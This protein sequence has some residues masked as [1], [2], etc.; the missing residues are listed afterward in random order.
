MFKAISVSAECMNDYV[1]NPPIPQV[2]DSVN[3]PKYN[4]KSSSSSCTGPNTAVYFGQ[5][6]PWTELKPG[7]PITSGS[8]IYVDLYEYDVDPNPDDIVK[9]YDLNF[10]I[11]GYIYN[12]EVNTNDYGNID[13][14]G[15][16]QAELYLSMI[17]SGVRY[18][19]V[20]AGIFTYHIC[21][22]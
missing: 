2:Y 17:A 4:L 21:M 11:D 13:S 3:T 10:D 5:I 7:V 9:T 18:G 20:P 22:N 12:I 1:P 16:N 8:V 6:K 19:Y 14:E 15:D